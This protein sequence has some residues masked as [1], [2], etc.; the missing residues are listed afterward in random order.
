MSEPFGSRPFL[1]SSQQADRKVLS[2]EP[3]SC[4]SLRQHRW[5]VLTGTA[6]CA[7]QRSGKCGWWAHWWP[8]FCVN[9][10]R[11][12]QAKRWVWGTDNVKRRQFA[13]SLCLRV[14]CATWWG[15]R[16][17]NVGGRGVCP[18]DEGWLLERKKRVEEKKD[19]KEVESYSRKSIGLQ[20]DKWDLPWGKR[21][22]FVHSFLFLFLSLS[23]SVD[24]MEQQGL[25]P[26]VYGARGPASHMQHPAVYSR[27]QFLRQQELYAFQQHQHQQH[28]AAQAMELAHR[29]SHSQVTHEGKSTRTFG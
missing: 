13:F 25:W 19:G 1:P 23:L 29:H 17:G 28:R 4:D 9:P 6:A 22:T 24:V 7:S 20:S 14:E 3:H 16:C 15:K 18:G 26:P 8:S 11:Y 21:K 5:I 10:L 2:E 27:S 12:D